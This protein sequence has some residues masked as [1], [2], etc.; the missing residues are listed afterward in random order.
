MHPP[1][2]GDM[3]SA[4][5]T[6][7]LPID[8]TAG[9]ADN[10]KTCAASASSTMWGWWMAGHAWRPCNRSSR[11]PCAWRCGP[12]GSTWARACSPAP[13]TSTDDQPRGLTC[14]RLDRIACGVAGGCADFVD[15]DR[16][17][18]RHPDGGQGGR[19][20]LRGRWRRPARPVKLQSSPQSNTAVRLVPSPQPAR[21]TAQFWTRLRRKL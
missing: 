10:L 1:H 9:S 7:T 20:V 21:A 3:V 12:L 17:R 2:H 14:F 19:A 13:S 4:R 18:S 8:T 6:A 15:I 5:G 16:G 11:R